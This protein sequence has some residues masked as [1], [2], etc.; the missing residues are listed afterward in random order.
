MLLALF[1]ATCGYAQED[2]VTPP[3]IAV[4]LVPGESVNIKGAEITFVEVLEDSRCPSSVDCI[5]N[6]RARVLLK[7]QPPGEETTET[8]VIF[9]ELKEGEAHNNMLGLTSEYNLE[10][11]GLQPYP[12]VPREE[13]DYT[14]LIR[15]LKKED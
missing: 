12:S 2:K 1:A 7:I 8:I 13:L 3:Q 15:K 6:G 4:K 11:I 14:L 9:G 5:W 10:V